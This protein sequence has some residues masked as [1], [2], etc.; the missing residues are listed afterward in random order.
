MAFLI[1]FESRMFLHV[2]DVEI[3]FV[4]ITKQIQICT[5]LECVT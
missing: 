3:S 2:L 1:Q 4:P 5:T